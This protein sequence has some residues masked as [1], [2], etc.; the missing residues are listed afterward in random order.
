MK[1]FVLVSLSDDIRIKTSQIV[2]NN[3]GKIF[4][5]I[6]AL[7]DY[8]IIDSKKTIETI[9]QKYYDNLETDI[10]KGTNDYC[11]SLK[12]ISAKVFLKNENYKLFENQ[13][14]VFLDMPQEEIKKENQELSFDRR[15]EKE[16]TLAVFDEV[17]KQLMKLAKITVYINNNT[18]ENVNNILEFLQE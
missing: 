5:D 7:I 13:E 1:D 4:L 18:E 6:D 3:L 10:I 8:E 14:F 17:R 16:N 2:A 11:N 9:G 15:I 12:T